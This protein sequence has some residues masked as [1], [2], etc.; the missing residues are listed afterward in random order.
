MGACGKD[1]E[2]AELQIECVEEKYGV[3]HDFTRY[4]VTMLSVEGQ[5]ISETDKTLPGILRTHK[6]YITVFALISGFVGL[7]LIIFV[8]SLI[9]ES[10]KNG[11]NSK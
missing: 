10:K 6:S 7:L 8:L 4:E 5:R 1:N 9:D 11:P 3:F 2:G